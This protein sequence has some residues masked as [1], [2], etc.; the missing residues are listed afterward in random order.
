M[1]VT[2][3]EDDEHVVTLKI[4]DDE[5]MKSIEFPPHTVGGLRFVRKSNRSTTPSRTWTKVPTV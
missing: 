2:K 4:K 1:T 5:R 3:T